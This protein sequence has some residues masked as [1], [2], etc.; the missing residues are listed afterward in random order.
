MKRIAINGFG[1]I[2]RAALKIILET[3]GLEIVAINDLLSIENAAYLLKF[4]SVYGRFAKEVKYETD[5]ELSIGDKKIKYFSV[6]DP[7]QLPWKS[8]NVDTVIES[9]GHFTKKEDASKHISAGA[10]TVVI[11]APTKSVDTPTVVHGVNSKDGNTNIFSCASCTTNNISPVIEIIGR[12]IGIQKA[13][14]NTVHA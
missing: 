1:R 6:K 14:L 11:S 5:D 3:P 10:R 4:D 13:I 2:G 12:R 8:L 7:Q 9:T